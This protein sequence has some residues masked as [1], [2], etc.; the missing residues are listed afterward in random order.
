MREL[1]EYSQNTERA[2]SRLITGVEN[3][4][5][6]FPA[7]LP[8]P[9]PAPWF[10]T[11]PTPIRSG[12]SRLFS[13]KMFWI[14]AAAIMILIAGIV[15]MRKPEQSGKLAASGPP[16]IIDYIQPNDAAVDFYKEVLQ[17]HADK[18]AIEGPNSPK[19]TAVQTKSGRK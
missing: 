13:M 2:L 12:L 18:N 17:A 1:R 6:E 5:R 10:E 4:T 16:A 15:H 19:R 7:G 3:L 11:G 9:E 8:A 14:A